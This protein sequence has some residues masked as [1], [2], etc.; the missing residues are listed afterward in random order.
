MKTGRKLSVLV[1]ISIV[2]TFLTNNYIP[3]PASSQNVITCNDE[4]SV[5][6]HRHDC[7]SDDY[8]TQPSCGSGLML[9]PNGKCVP[10]ECLMRLADGTCACLKDSHIRLRNPKLNS[11][12]VIKS[13]KDS[14]ASIQ[15]PDETSNLP[16]KY[17]EYK[18]TIKD[19][20][21]GLTPDQF[22]DQWKR[23]IDAA[24]DDGNPATTNDIKFKSTS[25]FTRRPT[26][27]EPE[28][29]NI[30]DIKIPIDSGSVILVE[31]TPTYFVF[32]TI[33]TKSSQTGSHPESGAREFGYEKNADGSVT[34]YT[35]AVTQSKLGFGRINEVIDDVFGKYMQGKGW[36]AMM[37]AIADKINSLGGHA[38]ASTISHWVRELKRTDDPATFKCK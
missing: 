15:S 13:L 31:N 30:Y 33:T 17:D 18:V 1:L 19:M 22:M 8:N 4:D 32:Q 21:P 7:D 6:D 27:P 34:F 23:D 9:Y 14:G 25:D 37:D 24:V 29:G 38:D 20:P 35:R 5:I 3:Y 2:F 36:T 16:I 26:T 11:P 10:K 28:V 12:Q